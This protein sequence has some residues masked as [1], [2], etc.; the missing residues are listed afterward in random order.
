MSVYS[1]VLPAFFSFII[2]FVLTGLLRRLA[3]RHNWLDEP[4]QR[5]SHRAPTP[6]SGGVGF[7]VAIS[8]TW[9]EW[10]AFLGADW[11]VGMGAAIDHRAAELISQT[12]LYLLALVAGAAVIALVGLVDDKMH[13]P[14]IL[15]L[16]FHFLCSALVLFYLPELPEVQGLAWIPR[17][18]LFVLFM[19]AMVWF[20]NLFNFMDGIDGIATIEALSILLGMLLIV[21]L[22]GANVAEASSVL[23]PVI[24]ALLAFLWW[25]WSPAKIFMG[26]A[27]SGFLG[28]FLPGLMLLV[29]WL[30]ELDFISIVMLSGVFVMD[31]TVTLVKRFLDR[32]QLSRAHRSHMYQIL[33]RRWGSHARVSLLVALVNVVWLL[34][35]SVLSL[36]SNSLQLSW[37]ILVI[38]WLPLGIMAHR[39]RAGLNND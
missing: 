32:Q 11:S 7:S 25:N 33:S 27:G 6:K 20:I 36:W 38:A 18:L 31:A 19:L 1:V 13:L 17:G 39:C 34:P 37:G 24:S 29:S 8:L 28:V 12:E 2:A 4:N 21:I 5:S 10:G 35:L 15:R 26:D 3:L 22:F 30:A 9:I 16:V 14:P 23:L